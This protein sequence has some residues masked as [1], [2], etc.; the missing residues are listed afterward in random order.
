MPPRHLAPSGAPAGQSESSG[1]RGYSSST[2]I[3]RRIAELIVYA[4]QQRLTKTETDRVHYLLERTGLS[5]E[6]QMVL[7]QALGDAY[8]PDAE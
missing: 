6:G 5:Y 4:Q 2:I 1:S 7:L 8:G 3:R